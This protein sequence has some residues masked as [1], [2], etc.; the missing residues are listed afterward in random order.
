MQHSG[1]PAALAP[2]AAVRSHP[3]TGASLAAAGT[4]AVA[5]AVGPAGLAVWP[6]VPGPHNPPA[7]V[8]SAAAV[9]QMPRGKKAH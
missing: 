1:A 9:L 8:A 4:P 5:A 2:A 3:A 6:A 7:L